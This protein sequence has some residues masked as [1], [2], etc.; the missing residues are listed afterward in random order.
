MALR[1]APAAALRRVFLRVA[2]HYALSPEQT[3]VAW[4]SAKR[5]RA[6]A[7]ACYLAIARSL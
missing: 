7:Y 5:S 4:E 2:E 6:H 3:I 1:Y